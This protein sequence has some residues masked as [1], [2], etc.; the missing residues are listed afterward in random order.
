MLLFWND[1]KQGRLNNM[2]KVYTKERHT[3]YSIGKD[4]S[5]HSHIHDP[6]SWLVTIRPLEIFGKRICSK[7][8]TEQEIARYINVLLHEKLN[9]ITKLI[10]DVTYFT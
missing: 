3:G 1:L 7:N 5:I 2:E 9:T 8:A 4:I 6:E 10:K